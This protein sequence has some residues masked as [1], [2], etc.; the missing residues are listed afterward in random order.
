MRAVL[1][2][3]FAAK[4]VP[5]SIMKRINSAWRCG[6]GWTATAVIFQN[7]DSI[8]KNALQ[9]TSANGVLYGAWVNMAEGGIAGVDGTRCTEIL[10]WPDLMRKRK[11]HRGNMA[12]AATM[13]SSI[14]HHG[15]V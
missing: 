10:T 11:T 13:P 5:H 14:I 15:G 4:Y 7:G 3:M 9:R 6:C 1:R 8:W 12:K 2:K